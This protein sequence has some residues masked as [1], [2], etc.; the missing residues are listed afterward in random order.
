MSD[1]HIHFD[2]D[3]IPE[4]ERHNPH[5]STD[6]DWESVL[7]GLDGELDGLR[8]DLGEERFAQVMEAL[9]LVFAWL[10]GT[11]DTGNH[12]LDA[13]IGRRTISLAIVLFPSL[14]QASRVELCADL[15]VSKQALAQSVEEARRFLKRVRV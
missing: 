6:F 15:E 2:A 1:P 12:G 7:A 9:T 5:A 8:A 3:H 4:S 10:L 11:R 14:V 13:A